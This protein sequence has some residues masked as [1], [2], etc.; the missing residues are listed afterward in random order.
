MTQ[1]GF[2]WNGHLIER[3]CSD[4]KKG[5]VIVGVTTKKQRLQIYI[6]KTGK[7]RVFDSVLHKELK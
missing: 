7:V 1:Y 4:E 5:W 3:W 6:T 2:E